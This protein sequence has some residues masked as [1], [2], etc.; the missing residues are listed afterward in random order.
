MCDKAHFDGL[1]HPVLVK[2]CQA[3]LCTM[4]AVAGNVSNACMIMLSDSMY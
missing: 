3:A 1:I 2:D 4:M